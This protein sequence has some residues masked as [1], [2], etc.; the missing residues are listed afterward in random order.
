MWKMPRIPL[1]PTLAA[2]IAVGEGVEH[3]VK[4]LH[5]LKEQIMADF[6]RLD[7]KL[8]EYGTAISGAVQRV[9]E[10]V[11]ALRDEVARLTLDAEDQAKVDAIVERMQGNLDAINAIDPVRVEDGDVDTSGDSGDGGQPVDENGDPTG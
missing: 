2:L 5:A 1:P 7:A 9:N 6:S 10:D 4:E 11:Q 8:D 3:I